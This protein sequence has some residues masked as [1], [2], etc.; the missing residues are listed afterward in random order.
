MQQKEL[1]S[2]LK[3]FYN[4]TSMA[5]MFLINELQENFNQNLNL[6][7]N[8]QQYCKLYTNKKIGQI[9]YLIKYILD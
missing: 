5:H 6:Q 4:T 3:Y 7:P 9:K 2:A 8:I 1:T